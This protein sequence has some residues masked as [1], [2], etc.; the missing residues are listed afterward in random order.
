M[1][2]IVFLTNLERQKVMMERAR[3]N[4]LQENRLKHEGRTVLLTDAVLWGDEWEKTFAASDIVFF[5]YMGSG[6][7]TD[8]LKKAA[9][10]LQSNKITH[11][12]LITDPGVDDLRCGI[13]PE[14]QE[15]LQKYLSYGG[16]ENYHNLWL[17]LSSRF[18]G[19]TCDYQLPQPLLW[20]GIYHPK[21]EQPFTDITEYR[22]L[23]CRPNRPT[24]GIVFYRDEWLWGDLAYQT[25]LVEEIEE[26]GMNAV[27][28]FTHG[29]ADPELKAPG[30]AEAMD[31]YFYDEGKATIDVLINTIKFSL[32][33]TRAIDLK[34][35]E[36]L[37]VP[38]L[39]VYTLLRPREEWKNC[40]EGMMAMEIAVSVTMPEFDGIIHSTPVAGREYQP[41]GNAVY[42][43]LAERINMV[44][45]KAKKWAKLRYIANSEKKIGIIFHNYPPTNANIG[46]AAGLDSIES[47]RLLL[48]EMMERGY[49]VDRIPD[50]S[51]SFINELVEHATN[52]RTYITDKQIQEAEKLS[53]Q[54][55]RQFFDSLAEETQAHLVRDWGSPPGDVFQY[56]GKLL[57]PGMLNGNVFITVQ[58]PRGFGED[59]S[60]IYH[61][62]DCAPTHHYL[63]YYHWLRDI[64]QADAVVHVGT[65]GSLEWLPGKSAALSNQ[66][67]PDLSIGDLPNIYPYW[68][69]VIGEGIQAKRRGA[70]CLI[71]YLSP[72]M[73][74]AGTYDELAELEKLLDE[75]VHFKQNQPDNVEVMVK[76]IR[77]KA[78]EAN[79]EED[80]PEQP[81]QPFEDYIQRLH[82][83]ITDIKN[84]QIRVGLHFLGC[85]PQD[86][87]LVEYL[88]ALTRMDSEE[89]PSLTQTLAAMYGF[90]YYELL[91]QSGKMLPDGSK[92]YGAVI[93]EIRERSREIILLLAEHNFS[94]D[95]VEGVLD[96]PWTANLNQTLCQQLLCVARYMCQTLVPNL[97]KTR[98]EITNLLAALEGCYVEPGP[99]GAPT[100]GML[101]VLPTG[102][103]FYGIDPRTMPTPP[104]WEI[105]KTMGDHIIERYMAEEGCYPENV[106]I[107]VWA[108]SNERSHGQCIAEFLY[109][110]GVRPVWQRGSQR[111]VDLEVIPIE[112]L[113]RPRIDVTARI[114][115]LFRD[116]M[117]M[118]IEW[119]DKAVELVANLDESPEINYVRKHMQEDVQKM[120]QEGMESEQAWEQARYRIF[121]DPPGTYGAGIGDVL[122]A[123]NWENID[124]LA[125]VYVRWGGH[126]YGAKAKGAFLP[127][128]FSR[129]M[130]SLDV[131]IQN[132]DNREISILNSDDYNA[133]HGGMIAAVRSL[134]GEAPRSFCGDSSDRQKVITRSLQD[135]IK[136]IFRGEAINPKFIEG[137]KEHGYRGAADLA[138]Y[139]AHSYQWDATSDVMEDWMYEKYA[140]KYAFDQEMQEWMKEVNPWALQRIVE[141]LLE[142]IQ[143][144][145]WEAD[146]QTKQELQNLY[147]DIEGELEDRCDI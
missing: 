106:G 34:S 87:S 125:R 120:E 145:L 38:V 128:L 102:R 116:S 104:A 130:A 109:L 61:S 47:I 144:G 6:L 62:P 60:K 50:D 58:P 136:R 56:D 134:K 103:N 17:W 7:D 10:F 53:E 73:S 71:G 83:Y 77:E 16:L 14:D 117:P 55:Y 24:V 115:G 96:L 23:F 114:S 92:T 112:E 3:E 11:V 74:N 45:R 59:P 139:V 97:E 31:A 142:A 90:D 127:E 54:Q 35:L 135:E 119:M 26:Q 84:M 57:V 46:G 49:Q 2:R 28:V 122:D 12:M 95:Q 138:C 51:Q 36:Q 85:P 70:A 133:Y 43:P 146:E 105:G 110:L 101:D 52:D 32:T 75:Y 124:D 113:K 91:D 99:G 40:L 30:L 4:L 13:T 18:C 98:Q 121:G 15:T 143:R 22:R 81:D 147:L 29:A 118:A 137:M 64:W 86:E 1:G 132:Q 78:K 67:Y 141:N 69:T 131:T 108:T 68:I 123:K 20:N 63:A 27:A 82:A 88:L 107:V 66:C 72:P 129:R 93:D 65:H 111:V 41:D 48:A 39:Q 44:A 79:L 8:F 126:A 19:E 80:I 9:E 76:L 37:N 5:T 100:C 21:A 94:V 140:E 33:C 42:L 25:A 89:I